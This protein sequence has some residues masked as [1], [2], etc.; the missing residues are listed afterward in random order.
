MQVY[1][2]SPSRLSEELVQIN[3]GKFKLKAARVKTDGEPVHTNW[4]NG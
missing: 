1:M 3:G 4:M 2:R